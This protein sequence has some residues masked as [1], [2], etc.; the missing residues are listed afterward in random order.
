MARIRKC[1]CLLQP[2]QSWS[3]TRFPN[4]NA[5][6]GFVTWKVVCLFCLSFWNVNSNLILITSS[7]D[8]AIQHIHDK[9]RIETIKYQNHRL[10]GNL[11]EFTE[12]WLVKSCDQHRTDRNQLITCQSLSART[13]AAIDRRC[14]WRNESFLKRN[15]QCK[16]IKKTKQKENDHNR[17]FLSN[18]VLNRKSIESYKEWGWGTRSSTSAVTNAKDSGTWPGVSLQHEKLPAVRR[19]MFPTLFFYYYL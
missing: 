8:F 6:T 1:T 2:I 16:A 19:F 11:Q 5:R 3:G 10:L 7:P 18:C 17:L 9:K 12:F 14:L 15:W 4:R 13:I